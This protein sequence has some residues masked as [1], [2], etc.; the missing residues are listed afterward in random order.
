MQIKTYNSPLGKF[1]IAVRED[2]VLAISDKAFGEDYLKKL[3]NYA[4]IAVRGGSIDKINEQLDDYFSG[5]RKDFDLTLELHGTDFQY[6]VWE[7][8]AKIPYGETRSYGEIAKAIGKPKAMRAVGSALGKNNIPIIIPCHRVLQS[9][10]KLGGFGWGVDVKK[11]LLDL[12][13]KFYDM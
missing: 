11:F 3:D 13:N 7:A 6:K 8:C 12:E 4:P 2:A 1:F 10:G 9:S 5:K